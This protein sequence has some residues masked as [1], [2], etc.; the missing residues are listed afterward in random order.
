[1]KR[2][3]VPLA[4]L[5]IVALMLAGAYA[6]GAYAPTGTPRIVAVWGTASR[7]ANAVEVVGLRPSTLRG[8]R[9]R[10]ANDVAWAGA[11]RVV[12]EPASVPAPAV[13]GRYT[14][15]ADRIRF[16][17]R[18]PFAAGVRY[19]VEFDARALG[20]AD[21]VR[22]THRFTVP[23][24]TPPRSTRVVTV[25]PA[26][27]RVP[28]NMLRWYL[29]FSAPMEPGTAHEH[30]RLLDETG[31]PVEG[32]FLSVGEEL[33][34]PARRRLT[35]LFDPGRVKR[36]VRAN[37]EMG[38]PL[39]GGHRYRL[40]V[41]PAWR[42]AAG[43]ML[44]SGFDKEFEVES[45]DRASPDP[46]RWRVAV[47]RANTREPVRVAFGEALDHAL[48]GRMIG[49]ERRRSR[50]E[51]RVTLADGDSVW[52]F[53]PTR[54]WAVGVYTLRIDAALEDLA[55]NSVARV[56]D[57]DRQRRVPGAE[58]TARAGTARTVEFRVGGS[59]R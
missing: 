10:G 53:S 15:E 20:G 48:A 35:M 34:D 59:N 54:A 39:V 38:T 8:L 13:I 4:G 41:D 36:G 11:L 40:V 32:A 9:S 3:A 2:A 16:K 52:H 7:V 31:R 51:G 18:F 26:V 22:L 47:P 49:V 19:L 46:A 37:L 45:P 33:W 14:A 1:M 25:H 44:A 42:D 58:E 30:V 24:A 56:F 17:P 43:A 28:S 5:I 6:L 12:V 23:A 27:D 29:E 21:T 57:A 55:G 50:V